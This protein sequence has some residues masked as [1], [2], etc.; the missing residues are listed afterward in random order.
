MYGPAQFCK[1]TSPDSTT[2]SYSTDNKGPGIIVAICII[3]G[4][5]TLFVAMRLFVRIKILGQ[6]H[7]DDHLTVLSLVRSMNP[8]QEAMPES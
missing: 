2:T 8:F 6:T 7:L 1:M 4:I 3:V 5:S